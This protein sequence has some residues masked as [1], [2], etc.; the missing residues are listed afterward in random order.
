[1]NEESITENLRAAF[2]EYCEG[3]EQGVLAE[4]R[5]MT[6]QYGKMLNQDTVS[7]FISG[8]IPNPQATTIRIMTK[9]AIALGIWPIFTVSEETAK[10]E[11]FT[12]SRISERAN[13]QNISSMCACSAIRFGSYTV[14]PNYCPNCGK[15]LRTP[16]RR[17]GYRNDPDVEYCRHC[18]VATKR[19]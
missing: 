10:Y 14:T 18:G 16:C 13:I 2:E 12:D 19:G 15:E 11:T 17:C 9:V 6:G 1:M 7:N 4:L 5:R 8:K 3:K